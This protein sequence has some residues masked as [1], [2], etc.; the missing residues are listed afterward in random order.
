MASETNATGAVRQL[1]VLARHAPHLQAIIDASKAASPS[2]TLRAF[3]KKIAATVGIQERDVTDV[4]AAIAQIRSMADN[5][6]GVDKA[7]DRIFETFPPEQ[8][9]QLASQRQTI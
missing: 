2:I 5:L 4:I 1:V 3:S 8:M 7:L 6:G 9:A